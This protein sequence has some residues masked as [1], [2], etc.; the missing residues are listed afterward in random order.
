MIKISNLQ[1]LRS[2][3]WLHVITFAAIA[4]ASFTLDFLN[5]SNQ[6]VQYNDNIM[7]FWFNIMI[8]GFSV[9]GSTASVYTSDT[10]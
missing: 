8:F 6:N 2:P 3:F 4:F 1:I 10:G 9:S 5:N 7:Y